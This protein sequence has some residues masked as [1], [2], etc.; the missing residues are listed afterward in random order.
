MTDI[1]LT[2]VTARALARDCAD[3][4]Q[5]PGAVAMQNI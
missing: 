3:Q 1:C 4:Q 5:V 2:L